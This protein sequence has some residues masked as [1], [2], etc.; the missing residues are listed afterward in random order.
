IE[1]LM[2]IIEMK[3]QTEQTNTLADYC[4]QTEQS[5]NRMKD[6]ISEIIHE[7]TKKSITINEL[8]NYVTSHLCLDEQLIDLEINIEPDLPSVFV[9]KIRFAR[10]ISNIFENA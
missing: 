6:M 8:L 1:G 9:N 2:S 4:K 10:A 5:I 7:N 3:L